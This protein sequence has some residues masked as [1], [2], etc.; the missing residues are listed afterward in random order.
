MKTNKKAKKRIAEKNARA[1]T[2]TYPDGRWIH[3][4]APN[5]KGKRKVVEGF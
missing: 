2:I 3:Y 5:K 4:Y 1:Y